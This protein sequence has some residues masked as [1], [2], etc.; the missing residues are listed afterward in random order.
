MKSDGKYLESIR[1][2]LSTINITGQNMQSGAL[3]FLIVWRKAFLIIALKVI[4][5]W[6]CIIWHVLV[7]EEQL[8]VKQ[9]W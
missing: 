2:T 9:R 7:V 4:S 3:R 8:H 5:S 6:T 1:R